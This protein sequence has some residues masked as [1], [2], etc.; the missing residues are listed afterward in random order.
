VRSRAA[1]L[2]VDALLSHML[3]A[4]VSLDNLLPRGRKISGAPSVAWSLDPYMQRHGM[5]RSVVERQP[6]MHWQCLASMHAYVALVIAVIH[7][8]H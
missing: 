4:K 8:L 7:R 3:G 2:R 6:D 1:I 5:G